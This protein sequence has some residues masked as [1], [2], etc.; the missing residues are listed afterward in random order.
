MVQLRRRVM[1][2]SIIIL[3][4]GVSFTQADRSSAQT[5]LKLYVNDSATALD[6][7][8]TVVGDAAGD[9]SSEKPLN[10]LQAALAMATQARQ[11]GVTDPITIYVDTGSYTLNA[12]ITVTALDH[13]TIEGSTSGQGAVLQAI[14]NPSPVAAL[15]L[16]D[17]REVQ[18]HSL[19]IIGGTDGIAIERSQGVGLTNIQI[20]T[21]LN[22]SIRVT[23]S[24]H[25]TVDHLLTQQ[26]NYALDVDTS[27]ITVT[28]S[29]GYDHFAVSP[30]AQSI[31]GFMLHGEP[32]PFTTMLPYGRP[33][34][35][36][37]RYLEIHEK[38][39]T[40]QVDVPDGS[41]SVCMVLSNLNNSIAQQSATV[42]DIP[43]FKD[44]SIQGMHIFRSCVRVEAKGSLAFNFTEK[45]WSNFLNQIWIQADS[46]DFSRHF[47]FG[48][49]PCAG[50]QPD[51][52]A[53]GGTPYDAAK[54]YGW[55]QDLTGAV[56]QVETWGKRAFPSLV[57]LKNGS[58]LLAIYSGDGH[59]SL[60]GQIWLYRSDDGGFHWSEVVAQVGD[61]ACENRNPA[62]AVTST[63]RV[64]L[65]YN[66]IY[67]DNETQKDKQLILW[68]TSDDE[69]RTWSAPQ[70]VQQFFDRNVLWLGEPRDSGIVLADGSLLMV[71]QA[72]EGATAGCAILQSQDDARTFSLYTTLAQGTKQD[73]TS[74]TE[75]A[76]ERTPDRFLAAARGTNEPGNTRL[77]VGDA[78]GKHW[79][80]FENLAL[81]G[82]PP[83]LV[84]LPDGE[85]ALITAQRRPNQL[86]GS[87]VVVT[88]RAQ[89]R[90][91][92]LS[93]PLVVR[94][95]LYSKF[96]DYGYP[97]ATLNANGDLVVAYYG[98]HEGEFSFVG[99]SV[100][101]LP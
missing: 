44:A 18:L 8:S 15:L 36:A 59:L 30:Q 9:G 40:F 86:D 10:S 100:V 58:L 3:V 79:S 71:V 41:Y 37:T 70:D 76:I 57:R 19:R 75:C 1:L 14:R 27:D 84:G 52:I 73:G 12:A 88:S 31:A 29:D 51:T 16:A 90:V 101:K 43:L 13:V 24:Q 74:N 95:D 32:A 48:P 53:E 91:W 64:V 21:T 97:S 93:D 23:Q 49:V 20:G 38:P 66:C 2:L 26:A 22:A 99:V 42:N 87:I 47:S 77:L 25:I 67:L 96:A 7:W 80:T 4:S 89:G 46:G 33:S 17:V 81:F 85:F 6:M 39:A 83:D 5:G 28:S 92:N 72:D 50:C 65:L 94:R 45:S 82:F 56:H 55:D 69:G 61:P 35:E 78:S 54:G 34:A 63:G 11:S 68:R 60:D 62:L 98:S